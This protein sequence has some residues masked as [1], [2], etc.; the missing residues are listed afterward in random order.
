MPNLRLAWKN[1][2]DDATLTSSGVTIGTTTPLTYMQNTRRDLVMK[3]ITG[4]LATLTIDGTFADGLTRYASH[5]SLHNHKLHGASWTLTLYGNANWTGTT[6]VVRS[7]TAVASN[8]ALS[9][10]WGLIAGSATDTDLLYYTQPAFA[11][12][13]LTAFKSFRLVLSGTP[14]DA[15]GSLTYWQVGRLF[16]GPYFE[17]ANNPKY[18]LTLKRSDNSMTSRDGGGGLQVA[19]GYAWRELDFTLESMTANDR[20]AM[21]DIAGYV[22]RWGDCVIS[23]FPTQGDRD[24]RDFTMNGR[25]AVLDPQVWEIVARSQRFQ[26]VEN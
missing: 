9:A 22:G 23:L 13:A 17:P 24:E 10:A 20:R 12:F 11:W 3:T 1:H 16:L 26:F 5:A 2:A 25:F 6:T 7:T 18:G 8:I 14:T 4:A 21:F 15:T 19:Q